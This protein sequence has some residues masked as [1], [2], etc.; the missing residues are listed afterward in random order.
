MRCPACG[1]LDDKVIDSRAGDDGTVIRRRRQCEECSARFTTFERLEE[2]P[3]FVI[4]RDGRRLPFDR[5]KI[6]SGVRSACKGRPVDESAIAALAIRVEHRVSLDHCDVQAGA[7][8]E[9]VLSELRD[10]DQVAAVRFAS[11]YKSFEG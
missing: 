8:G 2:V 6:E 5:S 9:M 11:V 10:L 3:T 1:A 7:V 4:K